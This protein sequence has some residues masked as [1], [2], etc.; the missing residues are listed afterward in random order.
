MMWV[1]CG[2]IVG[3]LWVHCEHVVGTLWAHSL[4]GTRV[5]SC[6]LVVAHADIITAIFPVLAL[7]VGHVLVH[8]RICGG[9]RTRLK[10]ILHIAAPPTY[11]HASVED[12]EK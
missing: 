12:N 10:L 9:Q 5:V 4:R 11:T 8:T 3:T 6:R 2:Y 1:H 7:P